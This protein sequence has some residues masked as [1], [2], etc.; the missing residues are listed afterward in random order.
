MIGLNLVWFMVMIDGDEV[1]KIKVCCVYF[2]LLNISRIE[3]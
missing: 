1:V 3:F 2:F